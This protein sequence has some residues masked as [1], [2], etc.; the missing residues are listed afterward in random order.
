MDR[1]QGLQ[2]GNRGHDGLDVVRGG[3]QEVNVGEPRHGHP[4]LHH[5]GG[6]RLPRVPGVKPDEGVAVTPV[7]DQ[8]VTQA[9]AHHRVADEL[10]GGLA[11]VTARRHNLTQEE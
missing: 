5:V 4:A 1:V 6:E 10:D 3:G 2:G 8:G 7:R 9:H 11:P